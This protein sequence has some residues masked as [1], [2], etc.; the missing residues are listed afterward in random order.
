MGVCFLPH[1]YKVYSLEDIELVPNMTTRACG[2]TA[3]YPIVYQ[4][5][6][7]GIV[8]GFVFYPVSLKC[9]V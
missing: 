2:G 8:R 3:V 6:L 9:I 1:V 5:V 4:G 7:G